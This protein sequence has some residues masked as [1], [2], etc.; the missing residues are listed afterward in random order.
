MTYKSSERDPNDDYPRSSRAKNFDTKVGDKK[1]LIRE[2]EGSVDNFDHY[3]YNGSIN[4]SR[5]HNGKVLETSLNSSMNQGMKGIATES[6]S[7]NVT[8][9]IKG[10]LKTKK[11]K[12]SVNSKENKGNADSSKDQL[13]LQ[14]Q[15]I[16]K[17]SSDKS[18]EY[19][20]R[21]KKDHERKQL[22]KAKDQNVQSSSSTPKN[23]LL[24]KLLKEKPFV[25]KDNTYSSKYK[26]IQDN[27][28]YTSSLFCI[29][30]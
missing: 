30:M 5:E 13:T 26:S 29:L 18:T 27:L 24:T 4:E 8:Q 7:P 15:S 11:A 12:I 22:F 19:D 2:T 16:S 3:K 20:H 28:K 14:T 10:T 9:D 1:S 17:K 6:R 23:N 21:L 25:F